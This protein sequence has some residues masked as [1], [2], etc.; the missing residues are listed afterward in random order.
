MAKNLMS[1]PILACLTEIWVP[2]I[3]DIVANYHHIQFQGKRTTQTQENGKK[4]CFRLDLGTLDPN[5]DYQ[6]FFLKIWL[7]QS[8]DI[9]V[10]DYHVKYQ[11]KN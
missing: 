7:R 8:V 5:S 11:K 3:F 1:G 10:N 4:P 9:M 6:L 2:K